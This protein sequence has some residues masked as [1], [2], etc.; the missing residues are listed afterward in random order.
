MARARVVATVAAVA[1]FA[2]VLWYLDLL[3]KLHP[4]SPGAAPLQIA[5]IAG[6]LMISG[7]ALVWMRWQKLGSFVLGFMFAIGLFFGFIDHFFVSGPDNVFDVGH[8][9][10]TLPFKIC[11]V[12]LVLFQVAGLSA[13]GR[14]LLTRPSA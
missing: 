9:D 10:W 2:G 11:V 4:N 7:L 13:S 3:P 14:M 1:N 5:F 8:G 12:A 6:A